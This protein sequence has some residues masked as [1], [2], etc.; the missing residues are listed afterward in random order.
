MSRSNASKQAGSQLAAMDASIELLRKEEANLIKIATDYKSKGNEVAAAD[1]IRR[2]MG[3]RKKIEIKL[4]LR[5]SLDD[6]LI[7]HSIAHEYA[8]VQKS[9]GELSVEKTGI[10]NSINVV[11]AKKTNAESRITD[12]QMNGIISR[13]NG[14]EVDQE[15]EQ[16]KIADFL[17]SL[18][19]AEV[20]T[21]TP[22]TTNTTTTTTTITK[23]NNNNNMSEIDRLLNSF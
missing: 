10:V 12:R 23:N 17:A 2:M 1:A 3:I 16:K 6:A 9:L 5:R 18:T 8:S 4:N 20:N 21:T 11:G 19:I 22:T 7:T 13:L 14:E 15:E